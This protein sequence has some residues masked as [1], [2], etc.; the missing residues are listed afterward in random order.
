MEEINNYTG[1]SFTLGNES[2]YTAKPLT[3]SDIREAVEYLMSKEYQDKC[4][5]AEHMRVA[6]E[7]IARC[8]F[9][10]GIVTEYQYLRMLDS[11]AFNGVLTVSSEIAKKLESVKLPEWL[12][13]LQDNPPSGREER[14]WLQK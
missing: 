11:L 3:S 8:A 4:W 13:K 12:E 9:E 6:G 1:L 2:D 5:K 14:W 10:Q 7:T